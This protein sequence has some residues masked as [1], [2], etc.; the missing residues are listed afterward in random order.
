MLNFDCFL[1]VSGK[2]DKAMHVFSPNS[3]WVLQDKMVLVIFCVK[4]LVFD[5]YTRHIAL[6]I[7]IS[8]SKACN[9]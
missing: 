2:N 1:I 4:R 6:P 8:I 9:N 5:Y 7:H 3:D